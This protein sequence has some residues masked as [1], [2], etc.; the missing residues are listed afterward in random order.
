MDY[1]FDWVSFI[2]CIF[3]IIVTALL[4]SIWAHEAG[5]HQALE[6]VCVQTNGKY[7]FCQEVTVK[8]YKVAIP[9][10]CMEKGLKNELTEEEWQNCFGTPIF[11]MSKRNKK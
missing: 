3:S 6:R 5:V 8:T 2:I 7:D 1:K 9:D 4:T 11:G 10:L